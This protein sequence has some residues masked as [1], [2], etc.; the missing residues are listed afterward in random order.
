MTAVLRVPTNVPSLRKQDAQEEEEQADASCDPSVQDEGSRL[1]QEGLIMLQTVSSV[2]VDGEMETHTR[3]I[4]DV[5]TLT[6][7]KGVCSGSGAFILNKC[8]AVRDGRTRRVLKEWTGRVERRVGSEL[9][10]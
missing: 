3:W 8:C 9:Q 4:L 5:W 10:R 1:V 2:V 6:A 7:S